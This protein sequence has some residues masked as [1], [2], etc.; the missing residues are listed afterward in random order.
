MKATFLLLVLAAT[1]LAGCSEGGGEDWPGRDTENAD[2][3]WREA[4]LQARRGMEMNFPLQT[5]QTLSFDW[6]VEEREAIILQI[7]YHTSDGRDVTVSEARATD[8][9]G[10]FTAR[11]TQLYSLSWMNDTEKDLTL[12]VQA[13][14]ERC[15][16]SQCAYYFRL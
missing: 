7:H 9:P 11:E 2:P 15:D 13:E 3:P 6:F 12:W 10:S 8:G 4:P 14:G 1:A 5:G 16:G